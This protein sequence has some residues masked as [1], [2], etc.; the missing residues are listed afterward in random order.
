MLFLDAL[1]QSY[2]LVPRAD[3]RRRSPSPPEK[4]FGQKIKPSA[5]EAK[6]NDIAIDPGESRESIGL[7]EQAEPSAARKT[8]VLHGNPRENRVDRPFV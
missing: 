8:H 4:S 5:V 7:I 2:N 3:H 6:R 1:P